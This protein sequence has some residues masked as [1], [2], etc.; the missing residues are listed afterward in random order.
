MVRISLVVITL[1]EEKALG[2]CL[3]SARDL[4]DEILIVDSGSTDRTLEIARSFD[5]RIILQPFLG[6]RLQKEFAMQQAAFDHVLALDADERLSSRLAERIRLVKARWTADGYTMNRLNFLGAHS[7]RH[8]GWYPDRKL[9]LFDRRKVILS[10][11]EP[12]D[13][14][15]LVPGASSAWLQGDILHRTNADIADRVQT[16][17]RFSSKA[18]EDLHR[19]GQ[20]GSIPRLLLKPAYRFVSE[21]LLQ[22]GFLDGF[23]GYVIARTSAQYVFLRE[24][25]LLELQRGSPAETNHGSNHAS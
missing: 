2:E 9:R 7:L 12:H 1:N 14:Y 6:Y 16:I 25:K 13:R 21:Y 5:A 23:A 24:A 3:A 19:R 8:G 18:A 4:V 11:A 15:D 17:N 10:G 22:R 20:R